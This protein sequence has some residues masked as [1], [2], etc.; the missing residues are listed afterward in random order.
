MCSYNNNVWRLGVDLSVNDPPP[1]SPRRSRF[2]K[3]SSP[4][5]CYTKLPKDNRFGCAPT[6][7][8]AAC[9]ARAE[10]S[11]RSGVGSHIAQDHHPPPQRATSWSWVGDGVSA[12]AEFD[13]VDGMPDGSGQWLQPPPHAGRRESS[14]D[15][16]ETQV[17][18]A[19]RLCC[20]TLGMPSAHVC[21]RRRCCPCSFARAPRTPLPL[22][23]RCMSKLRAA[24]M[25]LVT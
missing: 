2:S 11:H 7:Q 23:T 9:T 10:G 8:R 15:S 13:S 16:S 24:M 25:S 21:R 5:L 12:V 19:Y 1:N 14:V 17:R 18:V 20:T 6:F 22:P 4:M 3:K